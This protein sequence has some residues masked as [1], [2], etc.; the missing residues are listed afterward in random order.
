MEKRVILCLS[1]ELPLSKLCI[2]AV[3]T[4][5][6]VPAIKYVLS[7][8]SLICW[9]LLGAVVVIAG[10]LLSMKK[11]L[12]HESCKSSDNATDF[13]LACYDVENTLHDRNISSMCISGT[14]SVSLFIAHILTVIF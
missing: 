2:V 7:R 11:D 10:A 8:V 4:H 12:K 14:N 6:P 5:R 13:E 1:N 3:E 9:Q